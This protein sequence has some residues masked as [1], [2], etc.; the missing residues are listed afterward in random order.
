MIGELGV[1][2]STTGLAGSSQCR[3]EG[4][5]QKSLLHSFL[6][7][8]QLRLFSQDEKSNS[9]TD[10]RTRH[11]CSRQAGIL[12]I[13]RVPR[14]EDF[15]FWGRDFRLE[16]SGSISGGRASGREVGDGFSEVSSSHTDDS[17]VSWRSR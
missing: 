4:I 12:T 17:P 7:S 10:M 14:R 3:P 15:Y 5:L 9:S 13:L 6:I 1:S 11:A 8:S 2:D 16:F